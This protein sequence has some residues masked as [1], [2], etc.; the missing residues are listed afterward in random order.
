MKICRQ[1]GIERVRK[2]NEEEL[3]TWWRVKV[4]GPLIGVVKARAGVF[5][6]CC[7]WRRMSHPTASMPCLDEKGGISD[8]LVR[9]LNKMYCKGSRK[10]VEVEK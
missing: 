2:I 7:T 5:K 10:A 6:T 8:A 1:R 9:T 4:A 3:L